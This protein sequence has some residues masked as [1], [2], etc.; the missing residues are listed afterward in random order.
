MEKLTYYENSSEILKR[1]KL[2]LRMISTYLSLS[3]FNLS[4]QILEQCDALLAE[5]N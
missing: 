1:E 5:I 3:L 2:L 4:L